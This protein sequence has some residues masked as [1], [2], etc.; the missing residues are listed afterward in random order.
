MNAATR[1]YEK[2][3]QVLYKRVGKKY[4][5]VNDPFAYDGL[6]EGWWLIHIRSGCTSIRSQ[7][8]PNRAE[9][10]AAIREKSEKLSKVILECCEARPKE[11]V[12]LSDE[13]RKDWEEMI[14]KHGKEF[15]MLYYPSANDCVEKIIEAL[16]KKE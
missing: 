13:A 2:Q 15:N 4:V 3:N 14:R 16:L 1:I 8:Y 7:V 12:R 9:I 11:G 10:D 5:P 6:R